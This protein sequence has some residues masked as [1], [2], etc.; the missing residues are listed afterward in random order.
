MKKGIIALFAAALLIAAL[1]PVRAQNGNP[2]QRHLV[3]FYNVEN[4]FDTIKS[5]GV[6]DEEFTPQGP[7]QWNHHKYW[8]KMRN[9]ERVFSSI[10]EDNGRFPTVI[11]VSEVENRNVLEDMVAMPKLLPLNYQIV[12]YDS[13]DARGVDV[14]FFYRPDKF[15]YEGSFAEKTIVEDAPDFR[16]RDILTMWGTLEGEQFMF[17]VA[18]WPSRTGGQRASEPKRIGAARTMRNIIDSVLLEKPDLK[19]VLMG[20]LNDDPTD[21]SIA[22]VLGAMGNIKD[23][24][25]PGELFNP[26]FQLHRDGYGTLAYQDAWNLFDNIIVSGNLVNGSGGL[27]LW[28]PNR[29]KYWGFIYDRPWLKQQSGQYKGY[30]QRTYVGNKF[31]DGYSDHFPVFIWLAK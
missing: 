29:S 19:I 4:V 14:A 16:T 31:E 10:A 23:V 8:S 22:R 13:P 18:H 5:P 28:K 1:W 15:K 21:E 2:T 7:K 12:H 6:Y 20:D 9:L 25:A 30:P 26:Y 17:M 3:M 24:K 11:G 27:Q